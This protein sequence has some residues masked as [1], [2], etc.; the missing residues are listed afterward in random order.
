MA[1][2]PRTSVAC[3]C[4]RGESCCIAYA[5]GRCWLKGTWVRCVMQPCRL[6]VL[7]VAGCMFCE[8]GSQYT[9]LTDM[10]HAVCVR[11]MCRWWCTHAKVAMRWCGTFSGLA[12]MEAHRSSLFL[13]KCKQ[14]NILS[15]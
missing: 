12:V 9:Q 11:M 14:P 7:L 1:A 6:A 4:A 10:G 15:Q 13:S 8:L 3:C 2:Q 5:A